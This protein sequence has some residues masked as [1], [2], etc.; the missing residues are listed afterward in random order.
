MHH[1]AVAVALTSLLSSSSIAKVT[2]IWLLTKTTNYESN[3]FHLLRVYFSSS[4][5]VLVKQ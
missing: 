5:S 2:G 1:R 3:S 4:S